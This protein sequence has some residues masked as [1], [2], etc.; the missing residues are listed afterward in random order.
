VSG[1]SKLMFENPRSRLL[2]PISGVFRVFG[3]RVPPGEGESLRPT[4]RP[5]GRVTFRAAT[6]AATR[7]TRERRRAS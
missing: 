7:A 1:E 2:E 5:G 4:K 3:P 6:R